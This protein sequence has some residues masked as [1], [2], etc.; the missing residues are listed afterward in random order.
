MKRKRSVWLLLLFWAVAPCAR[1]DVSLTTL[2]SF[3]GNNGK[4]PQA[5]LT[6]GNDGNFYSPTYSGGNTDS[7]HPSGMGTVFRLT[8]KGTL[9]TLVD[10]NS[11]NGSGPIALTLGKD[12]NLY[13]TTEQDGSGLGTVFKVTTNGTLTTIV[14]FNGN[15]GAN[16]GAGLTL[17]ND[18][19]FYGTTG[20][21]GSS[22]YGTL[23]KVTTNG[24]LTTLVNFN[25]YNGAGPQ[26]AL[27]L[28]KDGNFYGTTYGGGNTDSTYPYGMGT[29]F[30]VTT[31]GT[32][33]T[34]VAF[35]G[36]NGAR[37][38]A[39]LTL[40]NDDNF[41]GTIGSGGSTTNFLNP[42]GMGTVFKVRTNG[43]LTTLIAFTSTT[44]A[45]PTAAL[46]LGNDGNFY[47]TTGNGGSSGFGTVFQVTTNGAL[48]TLAAFN[49][50]NG[51]SP[52]ALTLGSDGN[53]YGTTF[54]G[55]SSGD[56]TVFC[57][58]VA[59]VVTVQ[60][61]S[62]TNSPGAT[63]T[64][65][66]SATGL[67]PVAYQWQKNA[68][69]LANG[70]NIS[71]ANTSTLAITS[72]SDSDAASY[73]VIVSNSFGRVTSSNAVLTV[74]DLPF[75]TSQPQ[76]QTV[77]LGSNATFNV[78]VCGAPPFLFQW[79]FNGTPLGS[80]TLGTNCSS[81]TLANVGTNQAGN[82]S[83]WAVNDYGSVTSS[84]ASLTVKVFPPS[85]G[86]Q[87]SS[88]RVLMGSSASFSMS[89]SGTAPFRYQWRFNGTNLLSATNAA[90]AIQT[91]GT[92]NAGSYSVI[93]TNSAG[94]AMSSNALLTLIIPPTL[95]LQLSAGYPR[96]DLTGMLSN[97]FVVQYN[98]N[99][100]GANWINLL[101]LSNLP[102]SPYHFLDSGGVGKPARFYRV[103][104]Q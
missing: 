73:S 91:V 20:N 99:L 56:G 2:V 28:G 88:Q 54:A 55:G 51:S 8:T 72:I 16:P 33:T 64:F 39:A 7:T 50:N 69:N 19:N 75:I 71:G 57:L 41:Y 27:T 23:F 83:V 42:F 14:V 15:N 100:A 6:L 18:G 25:W 45:G 4:W 68:I 82:Y 97:N 1:A 40:G 74:S 78:S 13:G 46:T 104:M 84:N 79:C 63:V 47:G 35:N 60:P 65:H 49:W 66:A 95:A 52:N 62:Q 94:S 10:F 93:V 92:A 102:A 37:P 87:P 80:P 32:L 17:G 76:S 96:L 29:I 24:A 98:S 34:L 26:A 67:N 9:T 31:N 30:K 12:G 77:G 90:Y 101:S 38:T 70:G 85:I 3:N 5:A 36:N 61:Q 81:F 53:F 59:P 22:G 89:V 21:G 11:N 44:G 43:A 58:L 86:L 103:F 48:T